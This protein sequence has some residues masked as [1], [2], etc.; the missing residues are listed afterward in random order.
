MEPT[1]TIQRAALVLGVSAAA[2]LGVSPLA[3][4]APDQ[5]GGA[6]PVRLAFTDGG[7]GDSVATG[8]FAKAIGALDVYYVCRNEDRSRTLTIAQTPG[9]PDSFVK[10][11]PARCDGEDH[12]IKAVGAPS[13][14]SL[15][16][17]LD[18]PGAAISVYGFR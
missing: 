9:R 6:A 2:V 5:G 10:T 4:A 7:S 18:D 11:L 17:S 3:E 13:G 16:V 1:R 12:A 15:F 14:T 8:P